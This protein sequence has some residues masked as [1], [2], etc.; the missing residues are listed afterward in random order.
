MTYIRIYV[1][2]KVG[3]DTGQP[4]ITT[5]RISTTC[6][7]VDEVHYKERTIRLG[8]SLHLSN[9]NDPNRA[10][11]GHVPCSSIGSRMLKRVCHLCFSVL[12]AF[13]FAHV[14]R[15]PVLSFAHE[16][17]RLTCR[18]GRKGDS[19]LTTLSKASSKNGSNPPRITSTD[20]PANTV[21]L[22]LSVQ[23]ARAR[24]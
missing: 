9:P 15:S 11:V 13:F 17:G 2:C 5:F 4:G 6:T 1:L 23:R 22:P 18:I 24:A 3:D 7:F 8:N 12:L 14:F 19:S 21:C 16:H 10:I 20:V